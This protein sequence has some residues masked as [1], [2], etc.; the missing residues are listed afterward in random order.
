[1][2]ALKKHLW[3]CLCAWKSSKHCFGFSNI[4]DEAIKRKA[5]SLFKCHSTLWPW[6]A[7][8]LMNCNQEETSNL[9]DQPWDHSRNP[10]SN[11]TDCLRSCFKNRQSR[12]WLCLEVDSQGKR[13]RQESMRN[14]STWGLYLD[15]DYCLTCGGWSCRCRRRDSQASG[16]LNACGLAEGFSNRST[17]NKAKRPSVPFVKFS[18]AIQLW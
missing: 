6:R 12:D 5:S 18:N 7:P 14:T 3:P 9:Y 4:C 15:N 2:H 11:R 1:M 8:S 17:G 10:L 13:K 16:G